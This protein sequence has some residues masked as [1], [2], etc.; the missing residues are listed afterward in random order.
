[1]RFWKILSEIAEIPLQWTTIDQSKAVE[2]RFAIMKKLEVGVENLGLEVERKGKS[3]LDTN[4]RITKYSNVISIIE[5]HPELTKILLP[6]FSAPHSTAKSFLN[7]LS[8]N[9][10]D[11]SQTGPL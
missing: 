4:I 3:A 8:Q 5:S 10:L 11:F 7:Y 6:G 9:G 1:N 2:E